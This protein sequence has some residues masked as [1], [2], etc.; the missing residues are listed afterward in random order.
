MCELFLIY[1]GEQVFVCVAVTVCVCTIQASLLVCVMVTIV[2]AP[3]CNMCVKYV[4]VN[5]C[6]LLGLQVQQQECVCVCV[7]QCVCAVCL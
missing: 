6:I 2:C 3:V 7:C 4:A 1:T 5:G